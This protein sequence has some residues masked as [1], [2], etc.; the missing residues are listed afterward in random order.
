MKKQGK[1]LIHR[2]AFLKKRTL[3]Q[4]HSTA[5]LADI[6]IAE[7]TDKVISMRLENGADEVLAFY[8]SWSAAEYAAG[9][10]PGE[11][12]KVA[13]GTGDLVNDT[14][15][16]GFWTTV[17][18]LQALGCEVIYNIGD[19]SYSPNNAQ[20]MENFVAQSVVDAERSLIE[21]GLSP[22]EAREV[23]T[24]RVFGGVNGNYGTGITGMVQSGD[25]WENSA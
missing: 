13:V 8:D 19:G 9:N 17:R 4:A 1:R 2:A 22:K 24:Y 21:K 15:L 16:F 7:E 11:G 12:F 23:S 5:A 14:A 18:T 3:Q 6:T 10:K 20:V 25:R